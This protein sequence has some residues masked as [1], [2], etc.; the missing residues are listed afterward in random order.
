M[1]RGYWKAIHEILAIGSNIDRNVRLGIPR[2]FLELLRHML[3]SAQ[4]EL[5]L[6]EIKS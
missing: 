1:P 4:W 3:T 6:L 2:Q 5:C